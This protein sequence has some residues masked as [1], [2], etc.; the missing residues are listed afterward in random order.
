MNFGKFLV[1]QG[2]TPRPPRAGFPLPMLGNTG[3]REIWDDELQEIIEVPAG[4]RDGSTQAPASSTGASGMEILTMEQGTPEWFEARRGL[5]TASEFSTVLAKGRGGAE[6]KTRTTYMRKLAGEIIT[7]EPMETFS[8]NHMERGK[9]MEPEARSAYELLRDVEVQPV[10]FVRNVGL[11]AGCSPD[12]LVGDHGGVEIKTKMP[13]L[14]IE[15]YDRGDVCPPE[16]LA[17]VQGSMWITGRAWWDFVAYW[18]GMPLFHVRVE[19]D[20]AYI[21]ELAQEV[22]AFNLQLDRMV[23]KIRGMA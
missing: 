22:R 12:G 9:A 4:R 23:E 11:G 5:V 21:E 19:R 15:C 17:Q 13:H 8:N 6:S 7:G 14:M 2:A 18:P 16:H 1:Q 10:G 20:E 3:S